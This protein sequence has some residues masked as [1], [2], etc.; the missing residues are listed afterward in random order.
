MVDRQL[1]YVSLDVAARL[2]NSVEDN[3]DRY[4]NQG[5][6]EKSR[7]LGWALQTRNATLAPDFATGLDPSREPQAEISNSIHVF[8]SI[9]G[10][11]PALARDERVWVRLCHVDALDY[12]RERWIGPKNPVRD[13]E[14]H[15]FAS[16]IA[17]CRD[18]NALG[19]LWWNGYLASIID[20]NDP[21]SVLRE[22]L[23]RANIRLQ[24]VDRANTS[25][26]LPLAR[27]LI[28]LLRDEPWLNSHDRAFEDF[29]RVLDRNGGGKVFE[30][31]TD[32][33]IDSFLIANLP[34]AQAEHDRRHGK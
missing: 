9:K 3:I 16:G 19:R 1:G 23:K 12:A 10:M 25:F 17:Q 2:F 13:V 18:D 28:R 20:P 5:F 30:A 29:I 11:T 33:D 26:R 14:L 22:M 32:K 34:F 7:E 24:F 15:F 21:E 31:S 27:G 6:A 8:R 4:L